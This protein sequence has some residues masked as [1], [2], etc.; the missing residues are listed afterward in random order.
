MENTDI[1]PEKRG[2]SEERTKALGITDDRDETH[3]RCVLLA[4]E[5]SGVRGRQSFVI[6]HVVFY[7]VALG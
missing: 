3:V 2:A 5:S 6:F 7:I 4:E 1:W